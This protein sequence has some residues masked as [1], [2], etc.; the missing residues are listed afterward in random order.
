MPELHE[1]LKKISGLID[2]LIRK[3]D[4]PESICPR[5]L[6]KA[7]TDYPYTG[8]K[9]IRP[10]ILMW[11]CSMLGGNPEAAKYAAAAMEIYHNWTLV[12]DDIIDND[13]LRRG[14]PSTHKSVADFSVQ[15]LS[16]PKRISKKFGIDYAILAGDIQQGWAVNMLLKSAEHG[17]SGELAIALS[18]R[19]Q[20]YVNR[21]LISGQGLDMSY[22]FRDMDSFV[23]EEIENMLYMKTAV[24]LSFC[25]EAGGAIA[26]NCTDFNDNRIA[27]LNRF[28]TFVGVAFQLRDDWL[29]IFGDASKTGKTLFSDLISSKPT[30]LLVK[31][32]DSLSPDER[33]EFR[34]YIG[35]RKYT[36]ELKEKVRSFIRNSGAEKFVLD[37]IA[38]LTKDAKDLLGTFQNCRERELL[39][40]LVDWL[41]ARD[42]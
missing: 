13:N 19:L 41:L 17:V 40:D 22:P 36:P 7:V 3:D 10:A 18:R 29:G 27:V 21:M 9:R 23:A 42:R 30:V 2:E 8:G 24:L 16:V 4:F 38:K 31:T 26:L 32:I 20:E 5:F 37:K 11:C 39:I 1:E 35:L 34:S 12:H 28:A 14:Q 15:H 33:K 25:A 6:G